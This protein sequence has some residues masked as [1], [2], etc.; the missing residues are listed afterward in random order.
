MTQTA[1]VTGAASGMGHATAQHLIDEGWNV[2][3]L[4]LK[5]SDLRTG[6]GNLRE[7]SV[8]ITDRDAVAD[9]IAEGVPAGA[10]VDLV[11]NVAGIYP[12]STLDT[13]TEELYRFTFDVN[14]LGTL[15]VIAESRTRMEHG[16]AI[17]NFA[18][19]DAFTVSPGQ[20][21]YGASKAAIV[22][23]TKELALELA[24]H[25]I[26]VNAIAPGWVD[27]PGNKATGRIAEAARSIPLGRVAQPDEIAHWVL[28]L[29]TRASSFMTGETVVLSGGDVIR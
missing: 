22:M 21:L 9:A 1:I 28:T 24:P 8:D 7:L 10:H 16:G 15:N 20:L 13:F 14:V 2:L 18:S 26:R 19:V 11:A 12:P 4:D 5:E 3:A 17:V 27:T 6:S 29:G 23:L 25:G